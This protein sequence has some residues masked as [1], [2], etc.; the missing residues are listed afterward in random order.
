MNLPY[1]YKYFQMGIEGISKIKYT[2]YK[3]HVSTL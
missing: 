1:G 3:I 2:V